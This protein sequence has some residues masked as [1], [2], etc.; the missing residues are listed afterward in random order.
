[1]P[2]DNICNLKEWWPGV[3]KPTFKSKLGR[4]FE[5]LFIHILPDVSDVC[6]TVSYSSLSGSGTWIAPFY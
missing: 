4:L 1:M 3:W 6:G 5:R 2:F